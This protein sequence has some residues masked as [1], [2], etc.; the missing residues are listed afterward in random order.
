MIGKTINSSASATSASALST[1]PRISEGALQLLTCALPKISAE[2]FALENFLQVK[3]LASPGAIAIE[4]DSISQYLSSL[5]RELGEATEGQQTPHTD[6]LNSIL[7]DAKS[8]RDA[9]K[10]SVDTHTS[11]TM[12]T[13][14]L[15][16]LSK[17][18]QR[19]FRKA[20]EIR[21]SNIPETLELVEFSAEF[22]GTPD[23]LIP[24]LISLQERLLIDPDL[25]APQNGFGGIEEADALCSSLKLRQ[26]L[27]YAIR[28]SE[29]LSG[30]CLA[31]LNN[32][33]V[34]RDYP[35]I[36]NELQ[37]AGYISDN[38]KV[39][40]A[41]SLGIGLG[42]RREGV[43][44]QIDLYSEFVDLITSAMSSNGVTRF[45]A[46]VREGLQANTA[47]LDHERIGLKK[48]SIVT[49]FGETPYRVLIS[50]STK[51]LMPSHFPLLG[52]ASRFELWQNHPALS[53]KALEA[54]HSLYFSDVE[55]LC[56]EFALAAHPQIEV[57]CQ[58][59]YYACSIVFQL[60][61]RVCNLVQLRPR[62][63]LWGFF[64]STETPFS[65]KDAL[66]KVR[67]FLLFGY[68]AWL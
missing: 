14:F 43:R 53:C 58:T 3:P 42:A 64:G 9:L 46:L 13:S 15:S 36:V 24:Q 22:T 29:N 65:L 7:W 68:E 47:I 48:T 37:L 30:F 21:G 34:R 67:A 28:K 62:S 31:E 40:Y 10:E 39:G 16:S 38:D 66:P 12:L 33:S 5:R 23:Y 55:A 8:L 41:R 49:Y 18:L 57:N 20:L 45:F 6:V 35:E 50:S 2:I 1:A 56:K 17:I 61:P 60:G 44:Y 26:S 25:K 4:F 63:D 19:E 54:A 52:S 27:L 32:E 11:R 59:G 51:P